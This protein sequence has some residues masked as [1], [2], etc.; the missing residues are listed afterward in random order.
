[1]SEILTD[2]GLNLPTNYTTTEFEEAGK[3]L[4]NIEKGVQWAIGDWFNA[5]P[6]GMVK[7]EACEKAGIN[8]GTATNYGY[9]ANIFPIEART[10]ALSFTHYTAL[11]HS[12]LTPEARAQLIHLATEKKTS[13]AQLKVLINERLGI[14]PKNEIEGLENKFDALRDTFAESLPKGLSSKLASKVKGELFKITD[15]MSKD[16]TTQVN[17]A[18]AEKIKEVKAKALQREFEAEETL[19]EINKVRS[20][21]T[22]FISQEEFKLIRSCLHTDKY[23][24]NDPAQK[25]RLQKAFNAFSKL[26]DVN[27]VLNKWSKS[28]G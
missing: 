12:E 7:K 19:K 24:G 9:V 23:T 1:M 16:F 5:I 25:D 6:N 3:F 10:S 22:S 2:V 18:A 21:V 26:S 8:Y 13:S 11:K 15:S 14:A 20:N 28:D 4:A 27:E 17:K